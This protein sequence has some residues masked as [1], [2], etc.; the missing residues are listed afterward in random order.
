MTL[1]C[2][3]L[4]VHVNNAQAASQNDAMVATFDDL[5]L[6]PES[7]WRGDETSDEP[8]SV[9]RSGGFLFDNYLWA[10]Y[11]FG[12]NLHIATKRLQLM[13]RSTTSSIQLL[14]MVRKVRLFMV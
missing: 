3:S 11:D 1:L 4:A 12:A 7:H 2:L 5:S 13:P 10:E 14:V 9:F 6:E 8:E